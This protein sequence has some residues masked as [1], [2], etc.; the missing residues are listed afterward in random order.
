MDPPTDLMLGLIAN[1]KRLK[2][3]QD[4][5]LREAIQIFES[6]VMANECARRNPKEFSE[7]LLKNTP[8][9]LGAFEK[10]QT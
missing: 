5:I 6:K 10:R 1:Q 9:I 3:R 4:N 2:P 8:G 7:F